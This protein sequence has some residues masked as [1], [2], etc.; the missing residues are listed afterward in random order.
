MV[1]QSVCKSGDTCEV[2]APPQK[3]NEIGVFAKCESFWACFNVYS[4]RC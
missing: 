4:K 1:K 2:N 3:K